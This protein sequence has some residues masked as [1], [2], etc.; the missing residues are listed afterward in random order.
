MQHL[1]TDPELAIGLTKPSTVFI[2][3]T[4]EVDGSIAAS[5]EHL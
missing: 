3:C 2:P 5:L 4:I 1:L